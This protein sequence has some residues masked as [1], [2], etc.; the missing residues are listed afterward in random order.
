[1][2]DPRGA[3]RARDGNFSV[4]S[5]RCPEASVDHTIGDCKGQ[6]AFAPKGAEPIRQK[7][8]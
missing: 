2:A 3:A 6:A 7:V 8:L 5:T 4:K 1:M